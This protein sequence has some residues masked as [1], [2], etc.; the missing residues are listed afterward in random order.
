MNLSAGM[1]ANEG[2]GLWSGFTDLFT[3]APGGMI[4][5]K[6][7]IAMGVAGSLW[8]PVDLGFM[9]RML[10]AKSI[11]QARRASLAFI[12]VITIWA[13]LM[14]ALG[15]YGRVLIPGVSLPDT[16][17]ILMAKEAMP[18]LGAGRPW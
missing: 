1:T 12:F 16:V 13:T 4:T 2:S 10:A 7:I 17:V 11:T 15:M 3:L 18:L 5:V 8:I 9:Q 14:V 6:G